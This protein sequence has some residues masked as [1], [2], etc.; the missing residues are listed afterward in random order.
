MVLLFRKMTNVLDET[1]VPNYNTRLIFYPLLLLA[2]SI[3]ILYRWQQKSRIY[4]LAERMPGPASVP[5]LGNAL[6]VLKKQPNGTL[7]HLK[8]KILFADF[9]VS[10]LPMT[11]HKFYHNGLLKQTNT[12]QLC[13]C[14]LL[15]GASNI[16]KLPM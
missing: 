5:F 15:I 16:F 6:L 3:W 2:S 9:M 13:K 1:Q 8:D 11:L 7:Y 12:S 10:F 4:K 14:L